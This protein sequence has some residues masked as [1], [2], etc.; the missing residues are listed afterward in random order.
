MN[1]KCFYR[2][3]LIVNPHFNHLAP[4]SSTLR[5]SPSILSIPP[6]I[7]TL[8][9]THP[10]G[11]ENRVS[12]LGVSPTGDALCT[13]SWDTLLKVTTIT[14]TTIS[15][16]TR[17]ITTRS[18]TTTTATSSNNNNHHHHQWQQQTYDRIECL[19]FQIDLLD[20]FDSHTDLA[21]TFL[22]L[23]PPL[24]NSSLSL[25]LHLFCYSRFGHKQNNIQ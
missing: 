6:T 22:L 15:I 18:I 21:L 5:S 11:H 17:S 20:L 19:R 7:L 16:T 9:T 1:R 24:T 14:T 2:F 12:C 23:I 25:T 3:A 4:L 8:L 13:G 10:V